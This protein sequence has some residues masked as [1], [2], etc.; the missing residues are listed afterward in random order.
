MFRKMFRVFILHVTTPETFAK[1]LNMLE[2]IYMQNETRN[3]SKTFLQ[4]FY[5][6]R[7]HGPRQ[8]RNKSTSLTQDMTSCYY[9]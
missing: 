2:N 9:K 3:V 8:N 7:K 5:V 1:C 4:T 6:T